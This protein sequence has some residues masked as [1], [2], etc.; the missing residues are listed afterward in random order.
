MARNSHAAL[1]T[2]IAITGVALCA[3]GAHAGPNAP[4]MPKISLSNMSAARPAFNIRAPNIGISTSAVRPDLS[5]RR[6][7]TVNQDFNELHLR[8]ISSISSLQR[9]TQIDDLLGQR[10][11]ASLGQAQVRRA[12]RDLAAAS[13]QPTGKAAKTEKSR[14]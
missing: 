10:V 4:T 3:S 9:Q 11:S 5:A 6:A 2:A 13:S 12:G 1:C 7:D 14:D 8:F